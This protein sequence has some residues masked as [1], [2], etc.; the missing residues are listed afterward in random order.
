ME[1]QPQGEINAFQ[2]LEDRYGIDVVS[3]VSK[4]GIATPSQADAEEI[5]VGTQCNIFRYLC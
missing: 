2:V 1:K 3:G 5:S 4:N